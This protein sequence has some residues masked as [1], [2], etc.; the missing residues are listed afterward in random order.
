[1]MKNRL[2]LGLFL[3]GT[4]GAHGPTPLLTYSQTAGY[5]PPEKEVTKKCAIYSDHVVITRAVSNMTAK[6]TK[7]VEISEKEVQSWVADAARGKITPSYGPTDSPV[8]T[9]LASDKAGREVTIFKESPDGFRNDSPAA[10]GL[11]HFIDINC[12]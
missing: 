1:M 12:Q 7:R 10:I 4:A 11:K 2:W 9:Y 8:I 3:T 5:V 6:E